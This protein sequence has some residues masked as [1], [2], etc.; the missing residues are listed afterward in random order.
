MSFIK[1]FHVTTSLTGLNSFC[2]S[3]VLDHMYRRHFSEYGV[4]ILMPSENG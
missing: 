2:L 1:R 3:Y 4:G